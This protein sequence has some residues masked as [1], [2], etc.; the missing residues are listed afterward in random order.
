MQNALLLLPDEKTPLPTIRELKAAGFR[1]SS[2]VGSNE[3]H[4][5]PARRRHHGKANRPGPRKED[6]GRHRNNEYI[7]D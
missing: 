1:I 7:R 4:G 3:P 5:P 6:P 2:A